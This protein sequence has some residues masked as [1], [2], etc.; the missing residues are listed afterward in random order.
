MKG[1]LQGRRGHVPHGLGGW[2]KRVK[3]LKTVQV[4]TTLMSR[5]ALRRRGL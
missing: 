5:F 3:M 2:K 4:Q 1:R